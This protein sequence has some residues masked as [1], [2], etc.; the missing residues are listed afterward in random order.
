VAVVA[1]L[2]FIRF[3]EALALLAVGLGMLLSQIQLMDFGLPSVGL[4]LLDFAV[5]LMLMVVLLRWRAVQRVF[6][7]RRSARWLVCLVAA[8]GAIALLKGVLEGYLPRTALRGFRFYFYAIVAFHFAALL[9]ELQR[10]RTVVIGWMLF[11]PAQIYLVAT[12][13]VV[14]HS[15]NPG[16]AV[17]APDITST[18]THYL[19]VKSFFP[20]MFALALLALNSRRLRWVRRAALWS[21]VGVQIVVLAFSYSRS[22]YTGAVAGLV[23][24]LLGA[25]LAKLHGRGNVLLSGANAVRIVLGLGCICAVGV[26]VGG[27]LA[28]MDIRNGLESVQERFLFTRAIQQDNA[29]LG[30]LEGYRIGLADV[31]SHPILG[32]GLGDSTTDM[33]AKIFHNG[34]LWIAVSAG[35]PALLLSL[36]AAGLVCLKTLKALNRS[37]QGEVLSALQLGFLAC[38]VMWSVSAA[39]ATSMMDLTDVFDWGL[40]MGLMTVLLPPKAVR[41]PAARRAAL[42]AVAQAAGAG[43]HFSATALGRGRHT[44]GRL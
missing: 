5:L 43:M 29:I 6:S 9:C 25:I 44:S 21:L 24:L 12:D 27:S 33:R 35:L 10:I 11:V 38:L 42:S 37:S 14:Y 4:N 40:L 17:L 1:F 19:P 28:G 7:A 20:M 41:E 23:A 13:T 22:L 36:W 16:M 15:Q 8:A 39:S 26:L 3:P 32:T 30:R 34:W 18:A 31:Y 2:L